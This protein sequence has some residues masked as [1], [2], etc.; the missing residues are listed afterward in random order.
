MMNLDDLSMLDLNDLMKMYDNIDGMFAY[1]PLDIR[2]KYLPG[3]RKVEKIANGD[4]VDLANLEE[5]TLK[6]G[7]FALVNLGVAME[8]P[9]GW[10]AH[11]APR[12][13]TF[14]K[15]GIIQVN[16]V[17]LIDASY[18]GD[19]DIWFMPVYA[20]RDVVIPAGTRIC[21]FR[22]IENQP[23]LNFV[24]VEH[25]GNENRGGCGSTGER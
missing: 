3:A 16:S 24:E 1:P 20:T 21:Q 4:W 7:E 2:I 22:V 15:W 18:C 14:K 25:L 17:G 13:S 11:V 5:V 6:A 10:E 8:L 12:S 19:D 9:E 23:P